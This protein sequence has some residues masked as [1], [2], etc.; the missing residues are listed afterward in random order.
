M[1]TAHTISLTRYLAQQQH[2]HG[3]PAD[4][5]TL[6]ETVAD[7][8]KQISVSVNKGA[9]AEVL[10]SAGSENVQGEVQKKL[11]IIANDMLLQANEWGG[12]LAAMASEELDDI[13]PIPNTYPQAAARPKSPRG[14]NT[15]G[16]GWGCAGHLGG[17]SSRCAF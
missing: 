11:D 17:K 3:L 7:T 14:A 10:G 4:L 5:R 2:T 9:L 1:P 6:I 12:Y 13:S 8:C 15:S 16:Q